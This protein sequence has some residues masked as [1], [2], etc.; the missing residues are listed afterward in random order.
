[1]SARDMQMISKHAHLFQHLW[2]VDG[3]V[4]EEVHKLRGLVSIAGHAGPELPEQLNKMDLGGRN[5]GMEGEREGGM[6]ES[7]KGEREE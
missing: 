3:E 4:P 1:M 2:C 7:R 6:E 5:G